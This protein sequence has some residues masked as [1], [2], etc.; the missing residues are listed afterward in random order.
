M[1]LVIGS[2]AGGGILAMEL[3][4]ADIPV[5]IIEKGPL[6]ESKDAYNYY[7]APW[8]KYNRICRK[9]SKIYW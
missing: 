1:V 7:D 5:T 6:V 8:W 4:K 9:C 3:A 2:G